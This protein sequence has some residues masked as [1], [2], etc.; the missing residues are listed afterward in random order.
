M[1]SEEVAVGSG[2]T[3]LNFWYLGNLI[4]QVRLLE[5]P[6]KLRRNEWSDMIQGFSNFC[7]LRPHLNFLIDLRDI[8]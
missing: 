2:F 8:V 6:L 5:T 3:F 7:D 4:E 1:E